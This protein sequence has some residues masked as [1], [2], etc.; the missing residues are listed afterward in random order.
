M[1]TSLLCYFFSCLHHIVWCF[2][3]STGTKL[4][5]CQRE[6][7]MHLHVVTLRILWFWWTSRPGGAANDKHT[8]IST[9]SVA[10]SHDSL[11]RITSNETCLHSNTPRIADLKNSPRQSWDQHKRMCISPSAWD[12][13]QTP[14]GPTQLYFS[15][16]WSA[17]GMFRL[18]KASSRKVVTPRVYSEVKRYSTSWIICQDNQQQASAPDSPNNSSGDPQSRKKMKKWWAIKLQRPVEN[19]CRIYVLMSAADHEVKTH[20]TS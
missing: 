8:L 12:S 14:V 9:E 16:Y 5:S 17:S 19:R 1:S 7:I 15:L 13:Q 6:S 11:G 18:S 2:A 20:R 10:S 4:Q 3:G